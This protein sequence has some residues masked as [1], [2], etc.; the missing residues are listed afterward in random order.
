[1]SST[2]H[3]VSHPDYNCLL[4][5]AGNR[6]GR[7][8]RV[9]YLREHAIMVLESA[10]ARI[11]VAEPRVIARY[12]L[13]GEDLAWDL[14]NDSDAGR[15][16]FTLP[17]YNPTPAETEAA[18]LLM[19]CVAAQKAGDVPEF[20]QMETGEKFKIGRKVGA[21]SPLRKAIA[22][23][24]K[25]FRAATAAEVWRALSAKPPKGHTFMDNRLGKY[26]ERETKSGR[27]ETKYPR[28][29]NIVSTEKRKLSAS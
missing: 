10:I 19:A 4:R 28:F 1:M 13:K 15:F 18:E 14:K 12:K 17:D 9:A 22:K 25:K 2:F 24:V 5:L 20:A 29:S 27:E 7:M 8:K 6:D 3:L 21:V 26:I 23:H 11:P 16:Y